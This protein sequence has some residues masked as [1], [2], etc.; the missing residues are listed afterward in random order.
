MSQTGEDI[1]THTKTPQT[2]GRQTSVEGP[3]AG[4][5]RVGET[6][7]STAVSRLVA[8]LPAMARD[9]EP[10]QAEL[11]AG[12]LSALTRRS[13]PAADLSWPRL[14]IALPAIEAMRYSSLQ[15]EFCNLIASSMDQRVAPS[16]LPAYVELLKQLSADEIDLLKAT[17]DYGLCMPVAD[18]VY[19]Y[20]TG[21]F[22][23]AYRHVIPASLARR[24]SIKSNIPQYVDNLTRLS[25]LSRPP[26]QETD[27]A[28]YRLMPRLAFV[29]ALAARAPSKA[30]ARFEKGALALTDLGDQF[31][32]LCL[33]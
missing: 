11:R 4:P 28:G 23:P 7:L 33:R 29:R 3:E 19:V 25:L 18:L 14:D 9:L 24:C 22:Q 1:Q 30:R 16:V 13:V 31:R 20:P 32:R 8:D 27:E 26:E 17:P 5:G 21:Q 10:V 2:E 15:Q 6:G 12:V